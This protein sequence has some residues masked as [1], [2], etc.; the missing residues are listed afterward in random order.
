MSPLCLVIAIL[1]KLDSKGPVIFKQ[2]RVGRN[3]KEFIMLKFRTMQQ[4][5]EHI[6]MRYET[7]KDDPRVTR[8]GK[9]IRRVGLDEIPQLINVIF[10][11]MS[12]VGPRPASPHQVVKYT[13]LEKKRLL[14]K[15]GITNMDIIKGGN[16]LPW[17]Q[18]IIWD[19]W[20][21]EHWSLWLDSKILFLTPFMI[22]L[23]NLQYDKDGISKDY[24]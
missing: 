10:D 18:R 17:K 19:I 8:V 5:T 1:I 2:K 22:L 11:G 16:N 13:E 9:V 20:Y 24:E 21:I 14:A 3:G 23:T 4:N 6:G 15:P 12:L 7:S